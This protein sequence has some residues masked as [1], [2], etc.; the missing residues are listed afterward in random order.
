MTNL[1]QKIV[2]LYLAGYS[3]EYISE[4]FNI[5]NE[6]TINV[7]ESHTNPKEEFIFNSHGSHARKVNHV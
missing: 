6:E 4:T 2:E 1:E 3:V 7:I 5:D